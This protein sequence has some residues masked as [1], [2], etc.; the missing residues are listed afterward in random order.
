LCDSEEKLH[1]Y[2]EERRDSF[3][4]SA[5]ELSCRSIRFV[6][7]IMAA[8]ISGMLFVGLPLEAGCFPASCGAIL[9]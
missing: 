4:G 3:P 5:R 6:A 2:E 7:H 1:P 8:G 9:S